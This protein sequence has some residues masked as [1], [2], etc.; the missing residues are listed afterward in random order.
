MGVEKAKSYI[1]QGARPPVNPHANYG[2]SHRI[3]DVPLDHSV[4]TDS[5]INQQ[6]SMSRAN[7]SN[8]GL[9]ATSTQQPQGQ[10]STSSGSIPLARA[11]SAQN[12][13]APPPQSKYYYEDY[14]DTP[15]SFHNH[16]A[17][18]GSI[19]DSS[20]TSATR[21]SYPYPSSESFARSSNPPPSPPRP[22]TFLSPTGSTNFTTS[23]PSLP[24]RP[25]PPTDE[26]ASYILDP[27]DMGNTHSTT[28][29]TNNTNNFNNINVSWTF[30]RPRTPD[31]GPSWSNNS[32]N[33]G[34]GKE[35]DS[36]MNGGGPTG[37]AAA[38]QN[39]KNSLS[40]PRRQPSH[41]S[42]LSQERGEFRLPF[43]QSETSL[44]HVG[45]LIDNVRLSSL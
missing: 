41:R 43:N 15:S 36:N 2:P 7:P 21:A 8:Y 40:V 1:P 6:P 30:P 18:A 20:S 29:T 35:F 27:T 13:N 14:A 37:G 38:G 28:T 45:D 16:Q 31:F 23:P 5:F 22:T 25:G 19:A 44:D 3:S 12:I 26:P 24:P 10:S 34:D 4:W 9:A 32:G 17:S 42:T 33:S 39:G 11:R